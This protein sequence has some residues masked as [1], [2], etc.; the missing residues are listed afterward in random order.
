MFWSGLTHQAVSL[1]LRAGNPAHAVD[2]RMGRGG[3]KSPWPSR[4]LHADAMEAV[5]K[6]EHPVSP[7]QARR[8]AEAAAKARAT[9]EEAAKARAE[10]HT[11]GALADEWLAARKI[12]N[13]PETYARDVRSV[14]YLKD[15]LQ[16]RRCSATCRSSRSRPRTSRTSVRSS[17]SRPA[18]A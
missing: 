5:A 1:R 4:R 18:S 11:C 17:T 7:A 12:G 2:R 10:Q 16:R 6:G 13:S 9:A 15:E 14:S 8:Q 3:G